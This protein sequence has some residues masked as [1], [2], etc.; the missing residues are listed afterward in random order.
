MAGINHKNDTLPLI[1]H[2]GKSQRSRNFEVSSQSRPVGWQKNAPPKK[3]TSATKKNHFS[4]TTLASHL[5]KFLLA[6]SVTYHHHQLATQ[7]T[8]VLVCVLVCYF[9]RQCFHFKINRAFI[10]KTT[11]H[12]HHYQTNLNRRDLINYTRYQIYIKARYIGASNCHCNV[13]L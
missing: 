10:E 1:Q 5:L 2:K 3:T 8:I 6:A 13:F 7:N 12:L 4:L 11:H 9:S